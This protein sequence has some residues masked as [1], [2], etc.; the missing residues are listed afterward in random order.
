MV[1]ES[2]EYDALWRLL[3]SH[4]THQILTMVPELEVFQPTEVGYGI[5]LRLSH[6]P[7]KSIVLHPAARGRATGDLALTVAGEGTVVIAREDRGY[8][9]YL[10]LVAGEIEAATARYFYP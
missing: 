9:E 3:W 4:A 6:D 2:V 5:G 1:I 10:Q 8:Y 7:H